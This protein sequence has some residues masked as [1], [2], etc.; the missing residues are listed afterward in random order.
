MSF[1]HNI[2]VFITTFATDRISAVLLTVVL[3]LTPAFFCA[4]TPMRDARPR[5]E[6]G[7]IIDVFFFDTLQP[8]LLDSYQR[9]GAGEPLYALSSTGA[10]RVVALAV[11]S[12]DSLRWADIRTYGDLCKWAFS[13]NED[14]PDNPLLAGEKIL[15]DGASRVADLEMKTCLTKV[16]LN[17][18][19]CDFS[20]M[21][22]TG[23]GY[24]NTSIYMQYAGAEARPFGPGAEYPVSYINPGWL[25]SATVMSYRN[26][27]MLLQ[28]GL[29]NIWRERKHSGMEFWCYANDVASASVGRPVTRLVLEGFVGNN[30]CYYPVE[31]PNLKAGQTLKVDLTLL[32]MGSPDPDI[33]VSSATVR[34]ETVTVPWVEMEQRAEIY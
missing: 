16:V 4:C 6:K 33:P 18:V 2:L 12:S 28:K 5:M 19:A 29:G 30:R 34:V 22:Y 17:S 21:P 25:D 3:Q 27:E 31:L 10:K 15:P 7:D 9:L 26:P 24:L 13:L 11:R 8:Q 1:L 14:S 20:Q 32:R 23:Q